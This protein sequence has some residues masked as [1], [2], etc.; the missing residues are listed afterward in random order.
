MFSD[1]DPY[2]D[3]DYPS[4]DPKVQSQQQQS[5]GTDGVVPVQNKNVHAPLMND[6]CFDMDFS[7]SKPFYNGQSLSQSVSIFSQAINSFTNC[8]VSYKTRRRCKKEIEMLN[9]EL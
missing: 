3:L 1:I 8:L 7:G 4:V 9:L 2:L 5:S 6:N